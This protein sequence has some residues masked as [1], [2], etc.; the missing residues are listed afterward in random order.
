MT[1]LLVLFLIFVF[2]ATDQLVQAASR[3]AA[4]RRKELLK[5]PAPL[6]LPRVPVTLRNIEPQGLLHH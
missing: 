3:R 6:T 1:V 5:G 4:A 2:V